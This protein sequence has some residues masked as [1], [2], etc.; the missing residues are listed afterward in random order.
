MTISNEL[1]PLFNPKV[2][3][4]IG[5]SRDPV[6]VSGF[7]LRNIVDG[8]FRGRVYPVNP[9][10]AA[11]I[12]GLQAVAKV[13][14][15]KEPIDCAV[16]T[17]PAKYVPET[18]EDCVS[19][20]VKTAIVISAGFSEVD[21]SGS[22]LEHEVIRIA[23]KGG[24]RFTGPN[25][26]GVYSAASS[27]SALLGPIRPLAGQIA[28][29]SQG[30]SPGV[31]VH[32]LTHRRRQGLSKFVNVGDSADLDISDMIDYYGKD[33][34]TKVIMAYFEG[35]KNGRKLMA[36]VKEASKRKPVL[37]MKAG[38]GETSQRVVASHVG[39]LAGSDKVVSAAL[40]ASGAIRAD[41]VAK[42]FDLATAF[43]TQ[44]IPRGPNLGIVTFGGGVGVQFMDHADRLN[45]KVPPLE[46]GEVESLSKILPKYWSHTNPVDTSD[47]AFG[48]GILSTCAET[49][50]KQDYIDGVIV[51]GIGLLEAFTEVLHDAIIT[52]M[53]TKREL[54]EAK[55][56]AELKHRYGK[57]IIGLTIHANEDSKVLQ[58][59]RGDGGVPVYED[60]QTAAQ[61]IRAML[62]YRDYL[63]HT[64][65][66][67]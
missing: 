28:F 26:N 29:V 6:S 67:R 15:I 59:L 44:P 9:N 57:P 14:K 2:V 63:K 22:N 32:G 17:L 8:G 46:N 39:A 66:N 58:Y 60:P 56:L 20:N 52:Q 65:N 7:V 3:A 54:D 43:S 37:V 53:G 23:R 47:G 33:S 5:A 41:S 61:A 36:A 49:L 31:I 50:L 55:L 16:F 4:C 45:L 11:R 21:E 35:L 62:D 30:G 19:Q 64:E 1:E 12:V 48:E 34:A 38:T 25:C 40:K 42:M 13:N 27:F 24:L 18:M 51:I 10:A